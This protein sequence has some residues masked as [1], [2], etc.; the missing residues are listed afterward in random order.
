MRRNL[1]KELM[2][3]KSVF[4]VLIL[5]MSS[6]FAS[7]S[8]M[9]GLADILDTI[10]QKF[11]T[12]SYLKDINEKLAGMSP[13]EVKKFYGKPAYEGITY[14]SNKKYKDFILVYPIIKGFDKRGTA[15]RADWNVKNSKHCAVISF[16]RENE[17]RV[18][19]KYLSDTF[20]HVIGTNCSPWTKG[21]YISDKFQELSTEKFEKISPY[22]NTEK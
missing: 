10:P 14:I 7:C 20:K 22:F 17:Y 3:M 1:I 13:S 5:V 18:P 2:D 4:N 11:G 21:S 12:P 19:K 16:N 15:L 6:Y 8:T 9:S